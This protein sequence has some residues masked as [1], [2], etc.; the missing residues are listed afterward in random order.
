MTGAHLAALV[1]MRSALDEVLPISPWTVR[2][3]MIFNGQGRPLLVS[4]SAAT[5]IFLRYVAAFEPGVARVIFRLL[6][7][8]L[9]IWSWEPPLLAGRYYARK[10]HKDTVHVFSLA[11][12]EQGMLCPTED[13]LQPDLAM[14]ALKGVWQWAK[15]PDPVDFA[16]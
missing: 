5:P 7:E 1:V 15:L 8:S 6:A 4:G 16:R 10:G 11:N 13:E 14:E 9:P 2:N 3:G 12:N